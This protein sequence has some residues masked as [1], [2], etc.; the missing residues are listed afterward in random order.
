M[1]WWRLTQVS[2]GYQLHNLRVHI[3]ESNLGKSYVIFL[4]DHSAI[5]TIHYLEGGR[6]FN[7]SKTQYYIIIIEAY[8]Q[9]YLWYI[10]SV[11][12]IMFFFYICK[13]L[14]E[15]FSQVMISGFNLSVFKRS[16]FGTY[17]TY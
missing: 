12:I 16:R 6:I 15:C 1:I 2:F 7:P 8:L 13:L 9:L 17:L 5:M 4:I 3:Y 10:F 14:I 11:R